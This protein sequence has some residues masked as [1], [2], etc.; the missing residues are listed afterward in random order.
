MEHSDTKSL[1]AIVGARHGCFER[2]G[3]RIADAAHNI[4]EY[5]DEEEILHRKDTSNGKLRESIR[6]RLRQPPIMAWMKVKGLVADVIYWPWMKGMHACS[7]VLDQC[8]LFEYFVERLSEWAEDPQDVIEGTANLL[9][10][11]ARIIDDRGMRMRAEIGDDPFC[12]KLLKAMLQEAAESVKHYCSMWLAGGLYSDADCKSNNFRG[13]LRGALCTSTP[14]ERVMGLQSWLKTKET[15]GH[16]RNQEGMILSKVQG[17]AAMG[18]WLWQM[19]EEELDKRIKV[20]RRSSNKKARNEGTF[21]GQLKSKFREYFEVDRAKALNGERE[22]MVDEAAELQRLSV[23]SLR[24]WRWSELMALS[25][26]GLSTQLKLRKLVDGQHMPARSKLHYSAPNRSAY[27]KALM[28]LLIQDCWREWGLCLAADDVTEEALPASTGAKAAG[29]S[30][31]RK[32]K[33]K[34]SNDDDGDAFFEVEEILEVRWNVEKG[35]REYWVKW[36]GY[37]TEDSIELH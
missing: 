16:N 7:H 13:R 32:A 37:R 24:C 20:T 28:P 1:E 33:A 34:A 22:K 30:G 25:N 36:V 15:N 14:V 10:G 4:L 3:G 35:E 11:P 5:L 2:N 8:S 12:L 21:E 27:L 31:K 6:W 26:A 18:G 9:V 19:T 29:N 17:T 23:P